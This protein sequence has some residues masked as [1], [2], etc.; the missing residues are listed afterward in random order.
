MAKRLRTTGPQNGKHDEE[1]KM[2]IPADITE[3]VESSFGKDAD[4]V[5]ELLTDLA[6]TLKGETNRVLRSVVFLASGDLA[7]LLHFSIQAQTDIRDVLSWAE[8]DHEDRQVRDFNLP[9]GG[10]QGAG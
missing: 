2:T 1:T 9:F 10:P 3:Y 4:A 6:L 7:K 8:Y 5:K